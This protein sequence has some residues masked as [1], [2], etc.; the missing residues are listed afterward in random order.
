M[1]VL[2]SYGAYSLVRIIGQY[3]PCITQVTNYML[4]SVREVQIIHLGSK[5]RK[6]LFLDRELRFILRRIRRIV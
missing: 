6:K 1:C 2:S 4:N 3:K 5:K